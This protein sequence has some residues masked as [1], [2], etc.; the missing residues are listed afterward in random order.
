MCDEPS[1]QKKVRVLRFWSK[2]KGSRHPT[3]ELEMENDGKLTEAFQ[4]GAQVKSQVRRINASDEECT[5][6][7][8]LLF[9]P[10]YF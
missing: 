3:V 9:F 5:V 2:E 1:L 8:T 10:F 6:Y 4:M 7:R